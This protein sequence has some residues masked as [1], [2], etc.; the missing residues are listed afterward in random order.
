MSDNHL[1]GT[2][3]PDVGQLRSLSLWGMFDNQLTGS[4]PDEIGNLGL[5]E[6]L[7]LDNNSEYEYSRVVPVGG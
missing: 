3:P 5:L 7:Y 4:V 2:L 6:V 1:T